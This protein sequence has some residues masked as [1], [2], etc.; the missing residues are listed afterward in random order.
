VIQYYKKAF[1]AKELL[2]I[3]APRGTVGHAEL[4]TGTSSVMLAEEFPGMNAKRPHSIGGSQL[5]FISLS[6][7]SILRLKKRSRQDPR[8][9]YPASLTFNVPAGKQ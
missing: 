7:T 2:R 3:E 1:G 8:T 5:D 6:K 4:R 9:L